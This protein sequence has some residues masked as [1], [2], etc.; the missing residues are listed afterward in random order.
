MEF[1]KNLILLLSIVVIVFSIW[2]TR[3]LIAGLP[4]GRVR[5]H[6]NSLLI[7]IY[8]FVVGYSGYTVFFW[9]EYSSTIDMIVPAIFF[10]GA[11]FV[12]LVCTLSM[13][14]SDDIKKIYKLE[15]ESTTDPLMGIN[16]RRSMEKKLYSEFTRATR[17]R[18]SL[19]LIMLDIDHFK[20]IND[21]LGHQVGDVVLK[22]LAVLI[23]ATVRETDIVCRYGGEEVLIILPHTCIV[24]ASNVAE[25]LRGEVANYKISIDE[26]E[27][28]G[29]VVQVTASFGVTALHDDVESVHCLLGRADR[30]LYFAKE[31]GRNKVASC[32]GPDNPQIH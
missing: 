32:L 16:N 19:S 15:Y 28:K 2:P 29:E 26:G 7:L 4:V 8:L 10:F 31:G 24:D 20:R 30:A 18:H 14:T 25:N 13:Q 9:T 3:C 1:L 6:W 17:Y 11:V 5:R 23:V 21:S 27:R 12:F 22:K